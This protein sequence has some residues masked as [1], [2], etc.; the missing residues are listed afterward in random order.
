MGKIEF[1]ECKNNI[2]LIA[3]HGFP[4]DDDYTAEI[5]EILARKLDCHAAINTKY[6]RPDEDK[7]EITDANKLLADFN[8]K[9]SIRDANL[10]VEWLDKLEN[11]KNKIVGFK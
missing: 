5:T 3:P 8:D 4:G 6:R 2:L 9:K 1:K 11:I 7:K 10:A